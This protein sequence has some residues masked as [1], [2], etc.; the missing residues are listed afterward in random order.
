M[1]TTLRSPLFLLAFTPL[2]LLAQVHAGDHT[3]L[4]YTTVGEELHPAHITFPDQSS[5]TTSVDLDDDGALDV[6]FT[7]SLMAFADAVS[8]S[9]MLMMWHDGVEV[10]VDAPGGYVVKRL[11]AGATIDASLAWQAFDVNAGNTITMAATGT[12]FA[13]PF[14]TGGD[15]WLVNGPVPTSGYV[16]VRI[17]EGADIR[18]GWVGL[19]SYVEQDSAW[20]HINDM[21]IQDD[22][23]GV[24]D[25]STLDQISARLLS[26][27]SVVLQGPLSDVQQITLHDVS[28]RVVRHVAGPAP[29]AIDLSGEAS[30]VYVLR[31][32]GRTGMRSFKL[33]W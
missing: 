9:N 28:G 7:S 13:G 8:G 17:V 3:D 12:G 29:Y 20:L 30:G 1:A 15:E 19:V 14:T 23:T 18:Y 6:Q 2:A 32:I 24:A 10:A 31:L 11:V 33:A 22:H 26:D 25:V 27:G 5:D 21:A 16:A 4:L